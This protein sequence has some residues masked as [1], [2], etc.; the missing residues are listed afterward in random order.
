M[1][2]DHYLTIRQWSSKIVAFEVGEDKTLVW[3][4]FPGLGIVFYDESVLLTIVSTIRRPIK[5]D[6]N[7]LN[8][9]PL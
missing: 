3:V 8:P 2:F 5:V 7:T 4:C 1:L 9:E 6:L